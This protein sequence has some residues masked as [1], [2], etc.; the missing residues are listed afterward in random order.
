MKRLLSIFCVFL[1][2]ICTAMCSCSEQPDTTQMYALDTIINITVYDSNKQALKEA[3]NEIKRLEE[4]FSISSNGDISR[5]NNSKNGAKVSFET[6]DL[7]KKSLE[8]SS[9]TNGAFDI[10]VYPAMHLWGFDTSNYHVP[11]ED[12]LK[13]VKKL[14]DY[15]N[16]SVDENYVSF[17][18]DMKLDLGAIAKG[19]IADRVCEVLKENSVKSAI[20]DLGGNIRTV[21]LKNGKNWTIG[22]KSPQIESS[23]VFA[24]VN[25]GEINAITSGAYQRYFEKDS[26]IYH[27]ILDPSTAAPANTDIS[28][29]TVFDQ[30]GAVCDAY[31][32]AM[33]VMGIKKA[34]DFA[35]QKGV[36]VAVLD[37]DMQKLYVTENISK[38]ISVSKNIELIVI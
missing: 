32:T 27:H 7:L 37:K 14:I 23:D 3:E 18:P 2:I 26:V 15:K 11:A 34:I 19:Y 4:L 25:V 20:I 35:K 28:S 8:I 17:S 30:D 29:V 16:V 36:D 6:A 38:N 9:D 33:F 12:E 22:I 24:K 31:S 13:E 1:I 21:G 10:T 5:L